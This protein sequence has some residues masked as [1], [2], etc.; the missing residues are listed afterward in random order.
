MNWAVLA[1][2]TA[3]S[4]L[5][6]SESKLTPRV[7]CGL[8]TVSLRVG[9]GSGQSCHGVTLVRA[10]ISMLLTRPRYPWSSSCADGIVNSTSTSASSKALMLVAVGCGAIVGRLWSLALISMKSTGGGTI[11]ALL[12]RLLGA[13]PFI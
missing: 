12:L 4:A 9:P 1:C 2:H 5:V 3:C 7:G 13:Q 8:M 6:L 10:Y 11:F